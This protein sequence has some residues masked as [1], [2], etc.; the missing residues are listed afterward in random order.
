MHEFS[1][2]GTF[3]LVGRVKT[4]PKMVTSSDFFSSL[5]RKIVY[6]PGRLNYLNLKG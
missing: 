4:K 1:S 3:R 6:S 5:K 2:G